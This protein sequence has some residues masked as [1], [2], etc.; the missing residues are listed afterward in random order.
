MKNDI[1]IAQSAKM[2]PIINIAKKIGLEEDDIELYGKYKCKIS[3]DAI[4]RLENNKDGKLVLVTAI[5]PTP[6]GE[7]KSTVTVGLGQALNKI[8]KNTVIALREPSLG[9]VFGIKGGAAGGGYAQVVPMEDINLHFTGDMHAITSAN[10][11]LCA[12]IDNHIHQGNLLRIDSR[13]IVFKRVMDMNDRALRN[14]VVGMGGKINGFLREDGF[15]ITVASEIMAILC[16][17]S[18]LEDLKERMGNILIAYNLDGEP[19]YAKELEIEGAMALL[20][21]DA[22]KPNLVQTLENT[23]AII[24]GGP[25]ANIAH[26]C[27]SIIA[28]KTALK[29]SDI[30]I[31]EAGFGADLGAEKFLDIKCRYGNLNPDCVVLVATIRALKHHGGVKKDELNTSNVDALNKGMKNLEKQIENI[32]AYG[33]PVVVAIN[34]FITD[35]DE[36][37]KAIEDFC[38]NIGVEVSLTEVWEKGGEGGIDLANKVIKTMEIEPSNFKMIYDSEESIKDKILK[39]VQTIYGGKGVNYTPQALKQIAEIEKFNLDKLPICMAKTQYSL[40]DNPSLLGR[41]ENFDITV[42]EVRVSNGAGF[43]VVLTGDV[44]T[45]P[46]LP[47]VPAANRMDIK[48]NG[49]IVGLF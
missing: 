34:K 5:N 14:I 9:P 35:S 48:D 25:F 49:E 22:I 44:M 36:E 28:T 4:K 10:N 6:A 20:M 24:H 2:E 45:M 37:V 19:V 43:I 12:A 39:I 47:K 30:T 8:G 38:K 29:M 3:L 41:P 1:E 31:T 40:S 21:K 23:P 33:V 17:A 42:K 32:K 46:G 18:D 26:G 11:L 13:R 16:M 7:G 27:N 15:M